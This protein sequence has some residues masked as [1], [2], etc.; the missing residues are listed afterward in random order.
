V[1]KAERR[2][3]HRLKDVE[4]LYFAPRVS[5]KADAEYFP[6]VYIEAGVDF[7]DIRTGYKGAVKLARALKIFDNHSVPGWADEIIL[8]ADIKRIR[9]TRPRTIQLCPLPEYLDAEFIDIVKNRYIEYLTRTWKKI[10]YHNSELNIYSG[11]NESKEEFTVRCREQFLA[12]MREELNRLRII[13]KR[14]Q[15]Q[16]KEKY[17][18]IGETELSESAPL[19]HETSDKD[20]YSRYTERIAA[21]FLNAGSS[22][23]DAG[24]AARRMDKKSELEE[25]LIALTAE[26]LNKIALLRERYDKK[27]ELVDEYILRP[28]LKNINCERSGILWMPRKAE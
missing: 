3:M 28:N 6:C 11:A 7:N 14:I 15:E 25:R 23:A 17:L 19:T 8:D 24:I 22:S 21:M 12:Q 27:S 16:L 5:R 10:L 13:F 26:T 20:I 2:W 9:E 1:K 4:S 18:G